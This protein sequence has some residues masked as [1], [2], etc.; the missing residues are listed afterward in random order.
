MLKISELLTTAPEH[1]ETPLQE[2]VYA[3]LAAHSIPFERVENDPAKTMEACK[4]V[5][6][7]LGCTIAKTLFLTNRQQTKFYLY[8]LPDDKP[9]VTKEFSKTLGRSRVSFASA[10]LLKEKMGVEP[11]AATV[12]CLLLENAKDVTLVIDKEIAD[13]EYLG[14]TDGTYT[15]YMKVKTQNIFPFFSEKPFII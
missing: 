2:K 8:L 4:S 13:S 15:C 1:F 6:E 7:K 10:E 9:F 11:G 14:C 5:A 3:F 12:F